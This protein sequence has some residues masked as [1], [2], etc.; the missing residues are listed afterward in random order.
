MKTNREITIEVLQVAACNLEY[1][2]DHQ[3]KR[4]PA[5]TLEKIRELIKEIDDCIAD[6]TNS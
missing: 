1:V 2:R 5:N 3:D 4:I 6:V